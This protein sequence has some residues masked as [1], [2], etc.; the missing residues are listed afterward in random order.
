MGEAKR[1]RERGDD[2]HSVSGYSRPPEG[3]LS[4]DIYDAIVAYAERQPTGFVDS[5]DLWLALME[6]LIQNLRSM[7]AHYKQK[8][9]DDTVSAVRDLAHMPFKPGEVQVMQPG[10]KA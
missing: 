10:G 3:S 2:I 4:G 9:V 6:H 8:M 1:K 7:P 5:Q